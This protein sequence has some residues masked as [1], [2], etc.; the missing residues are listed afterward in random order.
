MNILLYSKKEYWQDSKQRRKKCIVSQIAMPPWLRLFL[1]IMSG[2]ADSEGNC[3]GVCFAFSSLICST[4]LL[5]VCLCYFLSTVGSPNSWAIKLHTQFNESDNLYLI[6]NW[7][8]SSN[9]VDVNRTSITV[10][11]FVHQVHNGIIYWCSCE[12]LYMAFSIHWNRH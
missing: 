4:C 12:C 5:I 1:V 6:K 11:N 10:I 7:V 3:V 8:W 2:D 9:K